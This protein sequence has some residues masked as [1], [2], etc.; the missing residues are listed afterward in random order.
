VNAAQLLC[1]SDLVAVDAGDALTAAL[2]S[3]FA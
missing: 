1:D 2:G 3:L